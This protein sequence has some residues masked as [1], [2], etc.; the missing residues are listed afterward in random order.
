MGRDVVE[1][2]GIEPW[3]FTHRFIGWGNCE[4]RERSRLP[5][6]H[7]PKGELKKRKFKN[8]RSP[9]SEVG[10]R[11]GKRHRSG[12]VEP[13]IACQSA[14]GKS[15]PPVLTWIPRESNCEDRGEILSAQDVTLEPKKK[16]R[17]GGQGD[18]DEY[19]SGGVVKKTEKKQFSTER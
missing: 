16:G 6:G 19:Y 17:G 8:Q 13:D 2:G 9:P 15:N 12:E 4:K 7:E 11:R 5:Q 1:G 14:K 10:Q 3:R 18:R